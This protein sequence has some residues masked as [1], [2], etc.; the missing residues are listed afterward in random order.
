MV[1]KEFHFGTGGPGVGGGGLQGGA[2]CPPQ[3]PTQCLF[4]IQPGDLFLALPAHNKHPRLATPK[5]LSCPWNTVSISSCC[6]AF[7]FGFIKTDFLFAL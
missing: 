7:P 2:R 1:L 5:E 6:F 4:E 3:S